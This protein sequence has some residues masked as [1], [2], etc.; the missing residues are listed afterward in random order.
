MDIFLLK[1]AEKGFDF[2]FKH[3]LIMV[4]T[5]NEYGGS[6]YADIQFIENPNHNITILFIEMQRSAQ[7]YLKMLFQERLQNIE[8][9]DLP[10][11]INNLKFDIIESLKN[12]YQLRN[13]EKYNTIGFD[14]EIIIIIDNNAYR[15]EGNMLITEINEFHDDF[16][17]QGVMNNIIKKNNKLVISLDN[18]IEVYDCDKQNENDFKL[19]GNTNDDYWNITSFDGNSKK[20]RKEEFIWD[21]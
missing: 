18:L 17:P 2:A 15:I 1:K 20:L 3:R 19:Y 10:F 6:N 13:N 9:F 5:I 8:Q 16:I 4:E 21:L 14:G 11:I 12:I 7:L